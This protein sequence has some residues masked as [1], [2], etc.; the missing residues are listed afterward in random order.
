[1]IPEAENPFHQQEIIEVI[2]TS[3]NGQLRISV[4]QSCK[5]DRVARLFCEHR[6][7][8]LN[9]TRFTLDGDRLKNDLTLFENDVRNHDVLDAFQQVFGG[10]G[11]TDSEIRQM[12]EECNSDTEDVPAVDSGPNNTD[13]NY[14]WYEDLKQELKEGY[15]ILDQSNSQDQKLL[16][17]LETDHLQP[18]EIIR[19]RNVYSWWEQTKLWRS[20]VERSNPVIVKRKVKANQ[21]PCDIVK[22]PKRN[23]P[24]C[25]PVEKAV[26]TLDG[27]PIVTVSG[28]PVATTVGIPGI[29]PVGI[30]NNAT[31]NK[32]PTDEVTPNKRKRL[33]KSLDLT[34]PSP[35]VKKSHV[36]EKEMKRMSVA[37]HLW[38]ERKMGG[39]HYLQNNRLRD[40]EFED[41]L[42]FTGPASK[43]K[44]MKGRT[45]A[46][47]RSLW[48]NSFGGKHSYR[49]DKKTGFENEF[50]RHAPNDQFCPF[51]HCNS[52]IMSQMDFDLVLLTPQKKFLNVIYEQKT[53]SS[54]QLFK[55]NC[56]HEDNSEDEKVISDENIPQET[57]ASPL[58]ALGSSVESV[59]D[60]QPFP[61]DVKEDHKD[62]TK[63][64]SE[65]RNT[66]I[67]KENL[68]Y[69][70]HI[71]E[72]RKSFQTF[73][74]YERHIADKHSE[75]RL[76]K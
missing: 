4:S 70:C 8:M 10:K 51:G 32:E 19:L 38:A 5:F 67:C 60:E 3:S 35:L 21:D 53:V 28:K 52:G 22:R 11:P 26:C 20:E 73:F 34:T 37:V 1:M 17:L 36:N 15:L 31:I 16:Y 18:Y 50:Q 56:V 62:D 57:I 71:N 7:W 39:V 75:E 9:E 66:T 61:K 25:T 43:W 13:D 55:E 24:D 46:Q 41:I 42:V 27:K 44:L 45:L 54:R 48:R 14:K 29:T 69:V 23:I 12:L 40:S 47:L 2:I 33:M 49:G 64:V 74:G 6:G 68:N 58:T 72:C 59:D 63:E 65:I 30:K 76:P